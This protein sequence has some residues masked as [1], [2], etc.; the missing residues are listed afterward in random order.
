L[1]QLIV[2]GARLCAKHQ[3]Q[4]PETTNTLRLILWTLRPVAARFALQP[5]HA[6]SNRKSPQMPFAS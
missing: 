4:Q 5:V 6:E 2:E 3:P 1:P